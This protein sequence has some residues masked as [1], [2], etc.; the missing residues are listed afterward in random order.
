MHLTTIR[1]FGNEDET[2]PQRLLG[3]LLGRGKKYW[4][5][6]DRRFPSNDP[7]I[8]CAKL[9]P[10]SLLV[11]SFPVKEQQVRTSRRRPPLVSALCILGGILRE[12]RLPV[13][14]DAFFLFE[15]RKLRIKDA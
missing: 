1:H 4:P 6:A 11:Y 5:I 9:G 14:T 2:G 7:R 10:V 15:N 13:H 8:L 12:V 3:L